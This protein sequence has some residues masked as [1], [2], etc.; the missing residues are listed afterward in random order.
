MT[1][2]VFVRTRQ[3]STKLD[4]F[5]HTDNQDEKIMWSILIV[6]YRVKCRCSKLLHYTVIIN[7]RLLTFYYQF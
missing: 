2:L 1:K 5:W 3:I 4:N 7:I 6:H